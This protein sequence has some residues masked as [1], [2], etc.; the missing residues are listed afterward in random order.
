MMKGY[1]SILSMSCAFG[2]IAGAVAQEASPAADF[3]YDLNTAGDGVIIGYYKGTATEVVIPAVIEDFPVVIVAGAFSNNR[4]VTSVIFPD[5]VTEIGESCFTDCI[6][7]QKV[8]L[9]KSLKVIGAALFAGCT[10]LKTIT[11]PDSIEAIHPGAFKN[12]GLESITIPDSVKHIASRCRYS[13][14]RNGAFENC[15]NLHTVTI[16]NGTKAIGASA[17]AGCTNLT[18]ITIGNGTKVIGEKAFYECTKLTTVTIGNGTK[19]IGASAFFGCTNLTTA[20]IGSGIQSIGGEAFRNCSSLTT[21]NIG[22]EELKSGSDINVQKTSY[23]TGY[24]YN[25]FKGCSSLSL[26]ER[27]QIR[28]TGY[29]GDFTL[30]TSRGWGVPRSNFDPTWWL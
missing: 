28:D 8:V 13:D 1:F 2:D 12:S 30:D 5:S 24:G 21:V 26:K 29:T 11:L 27:K 25:V 15:K 9:P 3:N 20:T 19:A 16:G 23:K 18:T 22:V 7:L 6:S 4:D 17:F 14:S 10:A